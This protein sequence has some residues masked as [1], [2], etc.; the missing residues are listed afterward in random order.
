EL[1][2][3]DDFTIEYF[4]KQKN[5]FEEILKERFDVDITET[6]ISNQIKEDKGIL[7]AWQLLNS[8]KNDPLQA[9]MPFELDN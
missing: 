5:F 7:K 9:V 1:S 6:L 3:I 4:P 8:I 2:N